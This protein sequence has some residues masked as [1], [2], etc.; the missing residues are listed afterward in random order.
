MKKQLK[1]K[2]ELFGYLMYGY[3]YE[4]EDIHTKNGIQKRLKDNELELKLKKV[5]KEN[6]KLE[7]L[8]V[9][10]KLGPTYNRTENPWIQIYTLENRSGVKGRYVGISF[11]KTTDEIELWIG[12]GRTAKKQAEI[13]ELSKGY[14]IKYSLIEPNLKYGFE[15]ITSC[16]EA[17]FINKKI[18]IKN[19]NE[20]E[21]KRD[22]EYITDLYKAYEARFENA[23]VISIKDVKVKE[24]DKS[25]MSFELINEK[26]LVL[27]Q[28]VGDLAKE[29]R[30]LRE[31]EKL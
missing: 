29:I 15:Y 17:I 13:Y 1:N 8:L 23:T 11:D 28:E 4:L 16:N 25:K 18:S 20:E 14:R 27:L 31:G 22:L 2:Q 26:L 5:T 12:F 10:L 21:F 24:L 9:E 19:F 6:I 7:N 3:I 30:E